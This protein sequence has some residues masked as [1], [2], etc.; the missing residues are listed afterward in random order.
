LN[1]SAN[2]SNLG[3]NPASNVSVT[4][5]VSNASGI[6]F[7]DTSPVV[8]SI[9]ANAVETFTSGNTFTPTTGAYTVE[10]TVDLDEDDDNTANNMTSVPII[11]SVD[12]VLDYEY[13][14]DDG[15]Y[16]DG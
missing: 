15:N 3:V 10:Y 5:T 16:V 6:V 8:A 2:V 12:D 1:L 7:T 11:Y 13:A 14:R 9:A 4:F